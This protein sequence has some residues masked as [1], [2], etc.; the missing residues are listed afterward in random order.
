[1][2]RPSKEHSDYVRKRLIP[3]EKIIR[4]TDVIPGDIVAEMREM[5][6]FGFPMAEEYG[7]AG[8]KIAQHIETI[9]HVLCRA[10]LPLYR[11][12]QQK[13]HRCPFARIALIMARTRLPSNAH[14]S[15]FIVEMYTPGISVGSQN[16]KMGQAGTQIAN[17]QLIQ[18]ILVDSEAEFYAV[19]CIIADACRPADA[20]EKILMQAAVAKMIACEMCGRVADRCVQIHGSPGYLAEYEAE[21][22]FRNASVYRIYEGTTQIMQLVIV[23]NMLREYAAAM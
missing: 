2:C 14:I 13:R 7:G 3:A 8:M 20:S 6:L 4:E 16:K 10:G 21:R 19:E 1:M 17:F 11:R 18:A 22:L 9:R 15:A 12:D 23:K 5:G